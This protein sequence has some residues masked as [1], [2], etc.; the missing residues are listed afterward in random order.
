MRCPRRPPGRETGAAPCRHGRGGMPGSATARADGAVLRDSGRRLRQQREERD[1]QQAAAPEMPSPAELQHRR[2]QAP[3]TETMHP[4]S[5]PA[6]TC[7]GAHHIRTFHPTP[8]SSPAAHLLPAQL[9]H[10]GG[11]LVR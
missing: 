1:F 10:W 3:E 2:P 9:E 4:P 5:S 6:G 8:I 7:T 11:D